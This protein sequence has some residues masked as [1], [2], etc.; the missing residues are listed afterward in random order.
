LLPVKWE[1]D[2]PVLGE[3][4]KVPLHGEIPLPPFKAKNHLVESD[5]FSSNQLKIQ[6]QW[7]HNP[8]KNAWSLSERKGFMRLKTSRIVDNL[9]L[10]PNTLTQRMEGINLEEL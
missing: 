4:G 5:H 2:W 9:Y 8:V 1:N 6:W 3:N 7:N 10:A